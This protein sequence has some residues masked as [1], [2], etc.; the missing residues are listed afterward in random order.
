MTS[1]PV[2]RTRVSE[3]DQPPPIAL[4]ESQMC[5]LLAAS[6]PLPPALRSAFLEACAYLPNT[7]RLPSA[8]LVRGELGP[9]LG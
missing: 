2:K 3:S 6:Y 5:A 8:H 7:D 9:I 4:T 1:A